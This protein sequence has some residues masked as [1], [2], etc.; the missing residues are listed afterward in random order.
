[1]KK[2]RLGQLLLG[3]AIV[4]FSVSY[5]SSFETPGFMDLIIR[6]FTQSFVIPQEKVYLQTD[7]PY[8]NAG[9]D[10]WFKGY[11]VNAMTHEPNTLSRY[12]YVELINR[13]DSVLSRQKIRKDSLG[14][15]GCLKLNPKLQPGYYT[16]RAYTYWMQN[17]SSDFFFRKNI[18]I[19]NSIAERI[20]SDI[21]YGTPVNGEIPVSLTF[22]N[23]DKSP[24]VN[25]TIFIS[26]SWSHNQ[27]SRFFGKT[28]SEGKIMFSM[29]LDS[30]DHSRKYMDVSINDDAFKYQNRFFVS[31]QGRD[32]DL[33]FFPEGGTF[34]ANKL[35]LVAFKAIGSDG[36]SVDVSGTIFNA[37]DEEVGNFASR[38]KGMGKF[39]FQ[40]LSNENY[41]AR[42][43]AANGTEKR[44]NLPKAQDVGVSIHVASNGPK[45]MFEVTNQT[46]AP[47]Q[48]LFLLV[49]CRGSVYVMRPL[50][51]LTGKISADILPPGIT[52]FSVID[53]LG[54]PYCERLFFKQEQAPVAVS[55][56][57]DRVSYGKREPVNLKFAVKSSSGKPCAGNFSVSV[58]DNYSV[59]EDST[60][61]HILSYLLLSS[62][63]K[64]YIE[65]PASYF[66]PAN[67]RANIENLDLLMLTQGWKRFNTSD[68]IKGK[69]AKPAY[70]LEVGQAISGKVKNLFGK[71]SVN[72]EVCTFSAHKNIFGIMQTDSLG[73]FL[74]SGID[75]PDSTTFILK[76]KKRKSIADVEIIPDKDVFPK[77]ESLYP[78]P[79]QN[80]LEASS[81]YLQQSKEQYYNEGGMRVIDLD[82]V[83]VRASAPKKSNLNYIGTP[84][85]E[86]SSDYIK[87]FSSMN[88]LSLMATVPG[89]RVSGTDI[90]I[91]G[92]GKPLVRVDGF[93]VSDFSDLEN[94]YGSDVENIAVFK[95]PSAA[96]YGI[97]GGNG[98]IEITLKRGS[99]IESGNRRPLSLV[100][101]KPLGYAKSEEFYVPKYE[102]DSIRKTIKPDLRTTIYWNPKLRTDS[103]GVLNVKFYTADKP[104]HYSVILEGITKD[105]GICRFVGALKREDQH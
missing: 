54:N 22:K 88:V 42:V 59:K 21:V 30:A 85:S 20:S 35:Q 87:R 102:V 24:L 95:G 78:L 74:F 103:T 15:D 49:H 39:M 98:V 12:L 10:L 32:F 84:D 94:Y 92:G 93:E 31:E 104:H 81:A 43:K 76:A 97:Q 105:G 64:G 91:R 14:F 23:T 7:K 99:D 67:P 33:Q 75:F 86:V 79:K 25:K 41:Y 63:L 5:A 70:Y 58:T 38:N 27:R 51:T 101:V 36:L 17:A 19:G 47:N 61:D 50:N 57:A 44:F 28:N 77:P 68:I 52:S 13:S 55:M 53:S 71:P 34:L 9:E 29:V 16:L 96:V 3:A 66:R 48:S 6:R 45:V 100:F 62:D 40:A 80:D 4:I 37:R 11:V 65:D 18:Y 83:T 73:R 72:C 90:S 69:I 26:Q 60:S 46:K 8:Y 82:E 1:M 2:K 56:E 89:V